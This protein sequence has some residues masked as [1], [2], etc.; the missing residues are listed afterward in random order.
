M[1][2]S[3]VFYDSGEAY[4]ASQCSDH[5]HDGDVLLV[6][7]EGRVAVLV[8]AWPVLVGTGDP[9]PAF[10]SWNPGVTFATSDDGKYLNSAIVGTVLLTVESMKAA[11]LG[12]NE[13]LLNIAREHG[14]AGEIPEQ[15]RFRPADS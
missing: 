4:D 7:R 3:H 14:W 6:P 11:G 8:E 15:E 13:A 9:G 1:I 5:I 2:R 10:H 12:T